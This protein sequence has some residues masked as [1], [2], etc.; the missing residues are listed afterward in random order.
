MK[1]AIVALVLL[2][3]LALWML[4][5]PYQ[6]YSRETFVDIPH[7]SSVRTIARKLSEAGVIRF[8]W[9]LLAAR[10]LHPSGVL[11]AGEY[12]FSTPLSASQVLSKLTR[13]D[14]YFVELTVPEGANIFDIA[15]LVASRSSLT[16][17]S[18][19]KA[20]RNTALIRDL[21][22]MAQ[23]LEGFL[24]PATYRLTH[25]TTADDL[26]RQMVAQFRKEWIR[27]GG[28][29]ATRVVT[30]ASIVEK[31][32]GNPQERPIIAG[33]FLN[34]LKKPMR[35]ES[36]PTVVY[37][38]LLEHRYNGV[39][40]KS[41]LANHNPYNTYQSDGLP[42]GPIANPGAAALQAVLHPEPTKYLFF[43]AKPE[44]GAHRF[45]ETLAEHN[46]AVQ[47]YRHGLKR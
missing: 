22:P 4:G 21:A 27:L 23:S 11:Q 32:T 44:G 6:G 18:F 38:A 26:C 40:H 15:E 36:D 25:S 12:Q 46:R 13:G 33:V 20:A 14:V 16:A 34:R 19:L 1:R 45:S 29:D 42:P 7:G 2:A 39:I 47:D 24:F 10:M 31:E 5:A 43:V 3:G 9:T 17:D 35:I 37:A 30:L 41:D 8:Q 28:G